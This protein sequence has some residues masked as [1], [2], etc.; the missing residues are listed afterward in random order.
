VVYNPACPSVYVPPLCAMGVRGELAPIAA[1]HDD[2]C[3][4][5]RDL[6]SP[7]ARVTVL[8]FY[9]RPVR[10][11]LEPFPNQAF[12]YKRDWMQRMLVVCP[13]GSTRRAVLALLVHCIEV[14]RPTERGRWV[15]P[16]LWCFRVAPPLHLLLFGLGPRSALTVGPGYVQVLGPRGG[17]P[18]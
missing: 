12:A 6:A 16:S 11:F 15:A 2:A 9:A 5:P 13:H 14:L 17:R 3:A 1:H 4:L 7:T 10:M 18:D 8:W